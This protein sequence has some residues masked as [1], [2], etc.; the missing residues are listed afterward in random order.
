MPKYFFL[1]EVVS[2]VAAPLNKNIT[3]KRVLAIKMGWPLY[4][5]KIGEIANPPIRN[6]LFNHVGQLFLFF[7]RAA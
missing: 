3:E 6:A 1:F 5:T 7:S 4:N 2:T